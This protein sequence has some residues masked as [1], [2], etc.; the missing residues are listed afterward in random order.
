[1]VRKEQLKKKPTYNAADVGTTYSCEVPFLSLLSELCSNIPDMNMYPRLADA[2]VCL[3]TF[4]VILHLMLIWQKQ[5]MIVNWQLLPTKTVMTLICLFLSN[6]RFLERFITVVWLIQVKNY[7]SKWTASTLSELFENLHHEYC[8]FA[9]K[10]DY[11]IATVMTVGS[12]G[13]DCVEGQQQ[14]QLT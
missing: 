2:N 4:C 1:M 10:S 8:P 7:A 5:Q 6:I 3:H 13:A 11:S 12:G 9:P 14:L